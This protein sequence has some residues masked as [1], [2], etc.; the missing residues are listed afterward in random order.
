MTANNAVHFVNGIT[1]TAC[2]IVPMSAAVYLQSAP[3]RPLGE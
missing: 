1:L 2:G 3:Q